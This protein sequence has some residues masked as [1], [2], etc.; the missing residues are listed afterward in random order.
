MSTLVLS[1]LTEMHREKVLKNI[2]S[3]TWTEGAIMPATISAETHR[4]SSRGVG[5]QAVG[6]VPGEGQS[7]H[8]VSRFVGSA[9]TCVLLELH[10]LVES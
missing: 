5:L 2:S 9:S 3:R 8:L 10:S 6:D 1:C 4:Y 7:A